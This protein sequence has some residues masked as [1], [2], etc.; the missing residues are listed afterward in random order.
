MSRIDRIHRDK[1]EVGGCLSEDVPVKKKAIANIADHEV[2]QK[3][4]WLKQAVKTMAAAELEKEVYSAPKEVFV[5]LARDANWLEG[6]LNNKQISDEKRK[7]IYDEVYEYVISRTTLKRIIKGRFGVKMGSDGRERY[8]GH[9]DDED[10]AN[11]KQ[12]DIEGLK[13]VYE[14]F[15]L[16]PQSHL[17]E[18][19]VTTTTDKKRC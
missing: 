3:V 14:S 19:A 12:W 11:E 5:Q 2:T 13:H 9:L 18:L 8:Q 1:F 17:D 7:I 15:L 16:L 4:R 6:L 10:I